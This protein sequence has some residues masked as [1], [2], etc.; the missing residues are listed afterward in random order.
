VSH[1]FS[2]VD[3]LIPVRVVGESASRWV[4]V[5]T[6]AKRFGD[7]MGTP[8]AAISRWVR[9]IPT[10]IQVD[11]KAKEHDPKCDKGTLKGVQR[12]SLVRNDDGVQRVV[13]D[14]GKAPTLQS[15]ALQFDFGPD[16]LLLAPGDVIVLR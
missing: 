13:L 8:V 4:P 2:A 1:G 6:S 10:C 7:M 14:F 15:K 3:V 11:T 9:W 5:S 16:D 12:D